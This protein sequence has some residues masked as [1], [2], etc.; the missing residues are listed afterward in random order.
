MMNPMYVTRSL[1][2]AVAIGAPGATLALAPFANLHQPACC[3]GVDRSGLSELRAV[4]DARLEGLR[5]GARPATPAF[6]DGER[7]ML[8]QAQAR[9][10]EL[11]SLRGGDMSLS[12][13]DLKIILITAAAV[14]VL[15]AI[16]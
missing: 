4:A 9:R 13:R 10:P 8:R 11:A 3:R 14:L 2:L 1:A 7:D 12:D 15:V 6:D 16:F 5:G